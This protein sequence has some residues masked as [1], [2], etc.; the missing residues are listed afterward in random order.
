MLNL[1]WRDFYTEGMQRA[2]IAQLRVSAL[3]EEKF[4]DICAIIDPSEVFA[5]S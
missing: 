5:V 1:N 2:A 4:A 3:F